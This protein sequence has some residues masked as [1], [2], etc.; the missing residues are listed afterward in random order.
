M[1]HDSFSARDLGVAERVLEQR[2][3]QGEELVT[4]LLDA[5]VELQRLDKRRRVDE[6]HLAGVQLR[7]QPG[8]LVENRVLLQGVWLQREDAC[9][10]GGVHVEALEYAVGV[11]CGAEIS[12]PGGCLGGLAKVLGRV[13]AEATDVLAEL[14]P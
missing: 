13:G 10:E 4:V 12:Q 9:A 1:L 3:K 11:A 14:L 8:K 5:V 6:S 7:K 2:Q